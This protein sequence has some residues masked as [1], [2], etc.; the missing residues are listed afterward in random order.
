MLF[1][2]ALEALYAAFPLAGAQYK[3]LQSERGDEWTRTVDS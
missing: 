3:A 2:A 1:T